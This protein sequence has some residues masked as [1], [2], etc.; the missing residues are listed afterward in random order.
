MTAQ[1]LSNWRSGRHLP[2]RFDT[3]APVLIWL[4][5]RAREHHNNGLSGDAGPGPAVRSMRDWYRLFTD[6]QSPAAAAALDL[7]ARIDAVEFLL[8]HPDP[9]PEDYDN[10]SGS[11]SAP[12]GDSFA[13][14]RLTAELK[15]AILQLTGIDP[16]TSTPVAT[17]VPSGEL[18]ADAADLL[19]ATGLIAAV[20]APPEQVR[21]MVQW[22]DPKIATLWGRA[23]LLIE[24]YRLALEARTALLADAARWNARPDPHSLYTWQQLTA[25]GRHLHTVPAV[26]VATTAQAYRFGD[27]ATAEHIPSSALPFWEA[28]HTAAQR[29]L[30]VHRL[31]MAT[32]V[33][34]IV[35]GVIAAGIAGVLTS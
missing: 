17:G 14:A 30:T 11:D 8:T 12:A 26:T 1:R 31:I 15:T 35:I 22:A 10:P 25:C 20:T 34:L 6:E 28:S 27:G 7:K 9:Q 3:I 32:V 29:Q 33:G 2:D 16:T 4:T 23:A 5:L 19:S 21:S 13:A 24:Q 18:P